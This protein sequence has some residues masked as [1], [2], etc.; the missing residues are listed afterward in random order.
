MH[1]VVLLLLGC[2]ALLGCSDRAVSA[3]ETG[4]APPAGSG[5]HLVFFLDPNGGPCRMQAQILNGMAS[6]LQ[7]QATVRYV[8]TTVQD[9]HRWFARYGVR[10]LPTLLLAD[11]SGKEI[12]RLAP[13]VKSAEEI[14]L[15]LHSLPAGKS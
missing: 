7:G 15:L 9:D 2:F 11:A 3:T 6:E 8:Q 10:A 1:K 13:G 5:Y 4:G 14:R 12:R